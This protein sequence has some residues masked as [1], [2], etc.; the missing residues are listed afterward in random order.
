[1]CC[2]LHP[3][4]GRGAPGDGGDAHCPGAGP[5][6]LLALYFQARLAPG[7][8]SPRGGCCAGGPTWLETG[9]QHARWAWRMIL[10][11]C[12]PGFS[13]SGGRP[14]C[15]PPTSAAAVHPS[16]DA[17]GLHCGAGCQDARPAARHL[18]RLE[19]GCLQ[20][21]AYLPAVRIDITADDAG[22]PGMLTAAT[23]G[24]FG[25]QAM[26]SC[27]DTAVSTWALC[28]LC[29]LCLVGPSLPACCARLRAVQVCS[30]VSNHDMLRV[31]VL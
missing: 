5:G 12:P 11:R 21:L 6:L 29:L 15:P 22:G 28:Y 8:R 9:M 31:V 13:W 18:A 23:G 3:A 1:M 24:S 4:T 30:A 2:V 17:G 19:P 16:G 25:S 20:G 7:W 14:T 27:E 10:L 26:P